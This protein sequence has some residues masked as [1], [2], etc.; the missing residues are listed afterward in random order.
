MNEIKSSM[1][2]DKDELRKDEIKND[3]IKN[4]HI[5]QVESKETNKNGI[6]DGYLRAVEASI[7]K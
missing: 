3:I 4:Q 6:T 1:I 2:V 5:A 7:D